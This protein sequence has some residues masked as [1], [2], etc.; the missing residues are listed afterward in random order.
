MSLAY[1]K[2]LSTEGL[3]LS[4]CGAGE[5]SWESLGQQGDQTSQ[6]KGNQP[7][8]LIGRTHAEVGALIL[9]P[10]NVKSQLI[11]KNL[12]AGKYRRQEETGVTEDER[13]LNGITNSMDKSLGELWKLVMDRRPCMLQFMGLQRV[14]HDWATE[15]NW[16]CIYIFK[17]TYIKFLHCCC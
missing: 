4:H 2:W 7:W 8:I 5:D 11:G 16:I 6:S 15:L 10:P 9:W 17:R 1:T 3:M 12:D 14:G 13:W